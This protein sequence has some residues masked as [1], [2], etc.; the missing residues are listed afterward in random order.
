MGADV[1]EPQQDDLSA[2]ADNLAQRTGNG[3]IAPH[4][5]G[6]ATQTPPGADSSA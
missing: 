3:W 4:T 2:E 5:I 1:T 6:A